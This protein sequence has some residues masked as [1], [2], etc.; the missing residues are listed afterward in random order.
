MAQVKIN[1]SVVQGPLAAFLSNLTKTVN[2]GD[3]VIS[4][5]EFISES[6]TVD[7]NGMGEASELRD[8]EV[9]HP[10]DS[11]V[12]ITDA[13]STPRPRVTTWENIYL[14]AVAAVKAYPAAKLIQAINESDVKGKGLVTFL[15]KGDATPT[16]TGKVISFRRS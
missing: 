3:T 5:A 4:C 2:L 8:L 15:D 1:D 14:L 12:E 10:A 11:V 6:I 9:F 7:S 13:G 16:N